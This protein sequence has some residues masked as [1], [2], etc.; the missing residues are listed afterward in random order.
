MT[1]SNSY[2]TENVVS[3]F[4]GWPNRALMWI[5]LRPLASERIIRDLFWLHFTWVKIMFHLLLLGGSNGQ[6]HGDKVNL[7][8]GALARAGMS[9]IFWSQP[10]NWEQTTDESGDLLMGTLTALTRT[11]LS[12]SFAE[13]FFLEF[14]VLSFPWRFVFVQTCQIRLHW[15]LC[16]NSALS[17]YSV[18]WKHWVVKVV[19]LINWPPV[20]IQSAFILEAEMFGCVISLTYSLIYYFCIF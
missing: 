8:K 15:S 16:W 3:E 7:K 19:W 2:T 9:A 13:M 17:C 5:I 10:S 14:S 1:A 4:V 12:P 11:Q 18:D 6:D 20:L